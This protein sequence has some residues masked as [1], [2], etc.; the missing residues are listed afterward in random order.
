[1]K[2]YRYLLS[3]SYGQSPSKDSGLFD[4]ECNSAAEVLNHGDNVQEQ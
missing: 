3:P 4:S 1:M 2:T